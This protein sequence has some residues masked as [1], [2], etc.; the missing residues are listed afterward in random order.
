LEPGWKVMQFTHFSVKEFLTLVAWH[1]ISSCL[2]SGSEM[3][4][5][6]GRVSQVRIRGHF[7]RLG[8]NMVGDSS[9]KFPSEVLQVRSGVLS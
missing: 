2:A 7:A 3:P 4:S 8:D 5:K 9:E 6:Q 1:F